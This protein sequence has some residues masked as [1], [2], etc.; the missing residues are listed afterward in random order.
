MIETCTTKKMLILIGILLIASLTIL[1]LEEYVEES[2]YDTSKIIDRIS[3]GRKGNRKP[4]K[5]GFCRI[6]KFPLK[7]LEPMD[8]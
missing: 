6:F 8:L 4:D 3:L 1:L 5:V 7:V 2:G